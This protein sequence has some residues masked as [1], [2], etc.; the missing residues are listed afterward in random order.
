[1]SPVGPA[2]RRADEFQRLL[3][4]TSS[5][6]GS[7]RE[8]VELATFARELEQVPEVRPSASFTAD[9]RERLM[10]AAATH[11]TPEP[12]P[13]LG[14]RSRVRVQ[15]K[16]TV[17][18]P[19]PAARRRRNR[20]VTV[21]VATLAVIGGATGTA[22]A[23]Q[24]A[25]PGDVLYPL[26]RAIEDVNTGMVSGDYARGAAQLSRA[27]NRLGEVWSMVDSDEPVNDGDIRSAFEGFA[28]QSNRGADLLM[29]DFRDTRQRTSIQLIRDFTNSRIDE[30]ASLEPRV[31]DDARPALT[32][33]ADTLVQID[34]AA[35]ALCADPGCGSGIGE[36][37]PSLLDDQA[38]SAS[39]ELLPKLGP[40]PQESIE[41]DKDDP[42]VELPPDAPP[43]LTGTADD[44]PEP[45]DD[46][47]SGSGGDPDD[48]Q[49]DL[50]D[51]LNNPTDDP[52]PDQGSSGGILGDLLGGLLD[53]ASG[54]SN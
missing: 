29:Q 19:G 3:E 2:R 46:P 22:V 43:N 41:A 15:E 10:A 1:M 47:T 45:G 18:G 20:R 38:I 49:S 8:L 30:L 51:T 5:S 53:G 7:S 48:E 36:L 25:L 4:G 17:G 11:L 50:G 21:V 39:E 26:K 32:D 34:Q 31:P 37:P 54:N 44:E 42:G 6:A 52:T 27:D 23:S 16:L 13:Q 12:P 24:N 33:A 28:D 40:A 14:R 35:S 9:L